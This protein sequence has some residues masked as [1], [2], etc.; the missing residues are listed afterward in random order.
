MTTLKIDYQ[1][2][3]WQMEVHNCQARFRIVDNGRQTGKTTM[4]IHDFVKRALQKPNSLWYWVDPSHDFSKKC[5]NIF[6]QEYSPALRKRLGIKIISNPYKDIYFQKNGA[7]I[8]FRTA[9]NPDSLVG[10]TLDGVIVNEAGLIENPDIWT[11]M[12]FPAL[13]VKRGIGLFVSTARRKN[14]FYDLYCEGKNGCQNWSED[15]DLRDHSCEESHIYHTFWNPT[16]PLT[17]SMSAEEILMAKSAR[18]MTDMKFRMEYMAEFLED[19]SDVFRNFPRCIRG[20][21]ELPQERKSYII[22]VDL[23]KQRDFTVITVLDRVS[24]HVVHHDRFNG[25]PWPVIEERI[26]AVHQRYNRG[27]VVVDGT[28]VGDAVCSNLRKKIPNIEVFVI[29]NNVKK[30]ELIENLISGIEHE[31]LSFPDVPS[32]IQELSEFNFHLTPS[33]NIRYQGREDSHDDTVISLA[34]A[35]WPFRFKPVKQL[36]SKQARLIKRAW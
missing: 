31:D 34:L 7:R 22:G 36:T 13:G 16:T 17:S 25:V 24:H 1:P 8:S 18:G 15:H 20:S 33:G 6:K 30:V 5:L 29:G 21:L 9:Q 4:A 3:K 10:E 32:L 27:K 19:S 14:W 11:Q 35:Y 28:G 2:R 26:R 23:G 12:L